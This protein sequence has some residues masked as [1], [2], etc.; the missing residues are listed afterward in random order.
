[1]VSGKDATLSARPQGGLLFACNS[2]L[3]WSTRACRL[4]PSNTRR[5]KY[6]IQ[7]LKTV[8]GG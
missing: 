1:M 8:M 5:N 4:T 7:Y 2:G 3:T 6:E